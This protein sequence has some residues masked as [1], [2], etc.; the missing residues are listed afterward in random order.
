MSYESSVIYQGNIVTVLKED[1]IVELY[2]EVVHSVYETREH[3][4]GCL[5]YLV[6]DRVFTVDTFIPGVKVVTKLP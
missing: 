4:L 5:S 1:D 2:P 3:N 6:D